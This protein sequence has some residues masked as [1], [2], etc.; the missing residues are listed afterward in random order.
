M[1][2]PI[3]TTGGRSQRMVPPTE[4]QEVRVGGFY[5]GLARDFDRM[6]AF[7]QRLVSERP[8]YRLLVEH[9]RIATALDAGAGTGFHSIL[10]S[11]LGVQVT[12]VDLSPAM[13]E[14]LEHR[15]SEQ[16]L[17][18]TSLQS[19]FRELPARF[20]GPVDAVVCMGNTLAHTL[21]DDEL[22]Q[23]LAMFRSLINPG[24]VLLVQVLNFDRILADRESVQSIRESDGITYMRAYDFR[25]DHLVFNVRIIDQRGATVEERHSSMPLK[26]WTSQ[27]LMR[28]TTAAGFCNVK[29]YGSIALDRFTPASSKDL[30]LVAQNR[31]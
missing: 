10:L 6:T 14:A 12:A 22:L 28:Q 9:H 15:A 16:G 26:P 20:R 31:S 25:D 18:I 30:V 8:F 24:G 19:S 13:L 27:H 23:T 17:A 4:S 11:M 2:R 7:D 3:S 5:D 29:A 21:T 1:R